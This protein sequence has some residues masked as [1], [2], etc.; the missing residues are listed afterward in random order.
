MMPRYWFAPLGL[1][2][3]Q[4][5]PIAVVPD[6]N[7]RY[8]VAFGAELGSYQERIVSCAGDVLD[9]EQVHFRTVGGEVEAWVSPTIRI[10]GHAGQMSATPDKGGRIAP[11]FQGF[12]GGAMVAAE[13]GKVGV[14][15]GLSAVP[16][17]ASSTAGK[18]TH[19]VPLGYLRL[20]RL[21]NTHFRIGVGG[22]AAPGAPPDLFRVG[23]GRGFG[24]VRHVG[25]EFYTGAADF[26]ISGPDLVAG[27][28]VLFPIG[29]VFDLGL[30]A[31]YR[32]PSGGSVGV[33]A[34]VQ[35]GA[36]HS[37]LGGERP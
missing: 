7:G 12:F 9:R 32:V 26:P 8:R 2:V 11:P 27:G 35:L 31:A 23:I 1:F 13:G 33:V 25:W 18:R 28:Q 36:R 30:T 37:A 4:T 20:G 15:L 5:A 21:D 24:R 14:G 34:R 22:P 6:S 29:S 3:L 10:T 17:G 19:A 16:E